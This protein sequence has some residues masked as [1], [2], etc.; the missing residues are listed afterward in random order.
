M[1][2]DVPPENKSNYWGKMKSHAKFKIHQGWLTDQLTLNRTF[3]DTN[4]EYPGGQADFYYIRL[5]QKNM[6]RAWSSP[7]W[8]GE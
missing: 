3:E 4:P 1:Y 7:V 6:Q 5:L 8:V 2:I